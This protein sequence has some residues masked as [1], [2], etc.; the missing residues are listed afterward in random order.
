MTAAAFG[1]P[2]FSVGDYASPL[3]LHSL[4]YRLSYFRYSNIVTSRERP[5]AGFD[6]AR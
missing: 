4:L 5:V 6:N 1:L 3:F 2:R